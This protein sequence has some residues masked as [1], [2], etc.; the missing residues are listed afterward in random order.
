MYRPR[1]ESLERRDLFHAAALVDAFDAPAL[2]QCPSY[3][4]DV[5]PPSVAEA[6]G[7]R[8]AAGDVNGDGVADVPQAPLGYSWGMNESG[9]FAIVSP[10]GGRNGEEATLPA[11]QSF[12][13]PYIEQDNIYKQSLTRGITDGTSN[14]MMSRTT[15]ASRL[16][17]WE[18]AFSSYGEPEANGIIAILIG[19]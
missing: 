12:L 17:V 8:V 10:D 6:G 5:A 19:L 16:D 4:Y 2:T 11:V 1:L 14:T 9:G 7:V 3:P 18:H 15:D 13:L